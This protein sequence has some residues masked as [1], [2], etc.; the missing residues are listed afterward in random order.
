MKQTDNFLFCIKELNQLCKEDVEQN[1]IPHLHEYFS[2]FWIKKGE[3]VHANN[4]IE[5][6]VTGDSIFFVPDG[7]MHRMIL[8]EKTDGVS[9]LFNKSF[10]L[11]NQF[12]DERILSSSLF[13]N[14]EFYTIITLAE[15]SKKPFETLSEYMMEESL[16]D[17]PY[18]SNLL[19][20][21][22]L[23]FLTESKRIHD[24]QYQEHIKEN[25]DNFQT[26]ILQFKNLVE[27]N[28]RSRKDVSFYSDILKIRPACLNENTKKLTGITAGEFI[29]NRVIDEAKKMLVSTDRNAKEIAYELGF[30]DPAYF[31][32]FFKKY[33]QNTLS[34]FRELFKKKYN[35]KVV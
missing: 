18:K 25:Q 20:Y 27:E 3:A 13:K 9:I 34:D 30:D 17:Q 6:S 4:F 15:N 5:Y 22:L 12:N 31:S 7:M 11:S 19:L 32:R 28:F 1:K 14:P 29:R 35:K 2:I 10:F 16:K 24:Q 21:L 23:S 26:S 33:T 8:T